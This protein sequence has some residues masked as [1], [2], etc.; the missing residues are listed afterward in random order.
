MAIFQD[1]ILR[2]AICETTNSSLCGRDGELPLAIF[3]WGGHP[4]STKKIGD[5]KIYMAKKSYDQIFV[6]T[7]INTYINTDRQTDR[8]TYSN[9][10]T[11][12]P[13]YLPYLPTY[14]TYLPTYLPTYVPMYAQ[15]GSGLVM[16]VPE[17]CCQCQTFLGVRRWAMGATLNWLWMQS[18]NLWAAIWVCLKMMLHVLNIAI[19]IYFYRQPDEDPLDLRIPDTLLNDV[20]QLAAIK[21]QTNQS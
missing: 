2:M 16:A 7:Y 11:H 14:P 12:L 13:A 9:I 5:H 8:Q 10:S 4:R 19:L 20:L 6:N 3:F 17:V 15:T 18:F 21:P 1:L